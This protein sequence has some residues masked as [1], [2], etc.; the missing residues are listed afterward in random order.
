MSSIKNDAIQP[1]L[2]SWRGEN[3]CPR[4]M[5][6]DYGERAPRPP[7]NIIWIVSDQQRAQSIAC[8]NDPNVHTPNID[9]MARFGVNFNRAVSGYPICCPFRG[10]MLTGLYH[11]KCVPAHEFPLPQGQKTIADVFNEHGYETAY[12]GKWHLDGCRRNFSM[13]VVP[14]ERRGG[15]QRWIGFENNNAQWNTWLHGDRGNGEE[16]FKLRGYET[17]ALTDLFI[18]YLNEKGS[19]PDQKPFFAVL[20]VQPPH[21]PYMAPARNLSHYLFDQIRLRPN[22]PANERYRV[23]AQ[24]MLAQYYAMVENLDDNI[25]RILQALIDNELDLNT[26]VIFFSDHGDMMGSHGLYGKVVPYEESVRIPFIISGAAPQYYGYHIGETDAVLNDVDIAPTTLGLCGIPVPDWME[27]YDYSHYR[28]DGA[29]D[30]ISFQRKPDEPDSAYIQVIAPREGCDKPWRSVITRDGW[31]YVCFEGE[32]WLLFN[33]KEDPYEQQNLAH[34]EHMLPKRRELHALL[35]DW[36]DRTGDAF[37]LPALPP[38]HTPRTYD[39]SARRVFVSPPPAGLAEDFGGAAD[40]ALVCSILEELGV[41]RVVCIEDC[42]L[43]LSLA[44][45]YETF[46][47]Q[48]TIREGLAQALQL[49]KPAAAICMWGTGGIPRFYRERGM[50]YAQLD[51]GAI[52]ALIGASPR[53]A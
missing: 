29:D 26:H 14:P 52:A 43:Y 16:R 6:A 38:E 48:Q 33:T 53:R 15:F 39:L 40:Y 31:K 10:T 34:A 24:K 42:D 41:N 18:D 49:G 19:A 51:K 4:N 20:S 44:G 1:Y 28:Y 12:Y 3:S 5:D 2:A 47:C 23:E 7:Q 11:N 32:E 35:Q 37:E 22:V 8:N 25:G 46:G 9:R 50:D 27:G 13:H 45:L 30:Y 17:D 36:I 21:E